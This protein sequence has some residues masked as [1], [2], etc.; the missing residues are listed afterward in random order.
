MQRS[1]L[2][3]AVVN[4][5]FNFRD[6]NTRY[7][8]HIG[9]EFLLTNFERVG[10][11][12]FETYRSEL[13]KPGWAISNFQ[14]PANTTSQAQPL[15]HC[16]LQAQLTHYF[17]QFMILRLWQYGTPLRLCDNSHKD[18]FATVHTK[19]Q[20][21]MSVVNYVDNTQCEKKLK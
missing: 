18:Q 10:P 8:K 14:H 3:N 7:A 2:N 9:F 20:F 11:T 4:N 19:Q 6:D 13:R 17:E 15:S 16:C 21:K 1:N 5:N 12:T